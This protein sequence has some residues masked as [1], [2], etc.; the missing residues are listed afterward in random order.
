LK[1]PGRRPISI[2]EES[3]RICNIAISDILNLAQEWVREDEKYKKVK[4][5]VLILKSFTG[6]ELCSI[7]IS[8][9]WWLGRI[10]GACL[11]DLS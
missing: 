11:C 1:G 9:Y 10:L 4:K 5:K 7:V 8:N 3:Y 2:K 6:A